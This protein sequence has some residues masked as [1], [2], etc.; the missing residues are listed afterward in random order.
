M[1]H[2]K[3]NFLDFP[4]IKRIY[5]S[6]ARRF[7]ILIN[8]TKLKHTLGGFAFNADI[9]DTIERTTYFRG[10]YE[11]TQMDFLKKNSVKYKTKIF[12]DVGSYIGYYSILL[13]PLFEKIYSFEPQLTKFSALNN[14]VSMNKLNHKITTYNL[15]LGDANLETFGGAVHRGKLLRS[16][17][18]HINPKGNEKIK[19]CKGDNIFDLKN[20]NI[21]IKIDVE[22]FEYQVLK[23]LHKLLSLN[24]CFIQIEVWEKNNDLINKILKDLKYKKV[25][26]IN[27]DKYYTNFYF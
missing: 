12:L 9:K 21:S 11:K 13:S 8:K 6:I 27:D 2:I 24:K 14:N 4:I 22:G 7:L 3:M 5:P 23:G 26:S 1:Y 15:G 18:F 16:S 10:D 25:H 19:I 20:Q 17:G